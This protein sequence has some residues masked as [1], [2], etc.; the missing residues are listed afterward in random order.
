VDRGEHA[1]IVGISDLLHRAGSPLK[2]LNH[3]AWP[4]D[5]R[6]R[7][8]HGGAV[9]L[10]EVSYPP[11]DPQP[12]LDVVDLA[13]RELHEGVVDDWLRRTAD[14]IAGTARMLAAAGTAAFHEHSVALF[15]A[16]TAPLPRTS[17]TPLDL[18][19]RIHEVLGRLVQLE[20]G[21]TP[22][23]T[24]TAVEI[25]A[26]LVTGLSGVFGEDAPPVDIVGELSA[27]A[28]A[29][30]RGIRL[31]RDALFT[32]RDGAQLLQ[33]EA[34]I[35]VAT[36]LNGRRQP[37][38]ILGV[39]HP[40]TTRAQEGLAVFAELASS[41]AELDRMRRLADR[42]LG[43]QMVVDGADFVELFRWFRDRTP[44]DE[45]A[46]ESAR[47][48]FRGGPLT[49]GAPFT[50]D[51]VYLYGLLEIANV[52]R[53][54]FAAGR[55]DVLRLLFVGKLPVSALPALAHCADA[56]LVA[57]PAFAPPWVSDPRGILA[58][59]TL[60]TFLTRIDLPAMVETANAL[61]ADCPVV[62]FDRADPAALA[63][64]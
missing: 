12:T 50:K 27:N 61:L 64:V 42:T 1:R 14:E 53:T 37:L 62:S 46:F 6:R 60:S 43:I 41:T 3:L 44:N 45:Q 7:F 40:G 26:E 17:V 52:I 38:K 15:G 36:A 35:H 19:H 29:S 11:F 22:P 8:L 33:H 24:R 2:V 9:A 16:P 20:I 23:P 47:R 56:G 49:G 55:V 25:Q 13:R 32:D 34:F 21:L 54:A 28:A 10:P 59:L 57:R 18:A 4:L 63:P 51:V 39:G 30:A 48:A 31:R 58:L 5:V